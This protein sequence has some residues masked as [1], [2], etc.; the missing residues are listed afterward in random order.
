MVSASIELMRSKITPG[1]TPMR[2]LKLRIAWSVFWGLGCAVLIVVWMRSYW[3]SDW[4]LCNFS[5]TYGVGTAS[6][7]GCLDIGVF[8]LQT[9]VEVQNNFGASRWSYVSRKTSSVP[10]TSSHW[11]IG[12]ENS[13]HRT[14]YVRAP[15]WF[16]VLLLCGL[17]TV[18][19]I[20]W[21]FSLGTLLL[22]TTLAA[23]V[24]G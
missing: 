14:W 1:N 9:L 3:R 12:A 24:L 22:A 8:D 11:A 18:S 17:A 15:Y 21:R 23:V 10:P 16:H 4:L 19:W 13:P 20:R 6:S 2:F 7:S 5:G